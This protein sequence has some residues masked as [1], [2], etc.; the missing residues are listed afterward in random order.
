MWTQKME[1]YLKYLN[2]EIQESQAI[3]RYVLHPK[4]LEIEAL[5][6]RNQE[7]LNLEDPNCPGCL[8]FLKD[9]VDQIGYVYWKGDCPIHDRGPKYKTTTFKGD[10]P[11]CI[12]DAIPG[13][14]VHNVNSCPIHTIQKRRK[15][16]ENAP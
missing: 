5:D 8:E 6:E 3:L 9:R 11:Q 15:E 16:I 12:I 13:S 14:I 10:C 7:L 4:L 1:D 2:Q